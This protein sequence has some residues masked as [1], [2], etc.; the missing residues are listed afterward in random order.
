MTL[1][2]GGSGQLG[3]ALRILLP[4]CD[5]P[6]RSEL[7]L[8]DPDLV[9]KVIA[10]NPDCIINCAAY[11]D[12]DRAEN[13][14]DLATSVNATA[15]GDLASA[16]SELDVPFVTI[17]TDYVFDGRATEPYMESSRPN[18]INAYG[19]SKL[20]GERIALG[21]DGTLVVR[22]SWLI[23]RTHD[24][25]VSTVVAAARS[26]SVGVVEGQQGTPTAVDDLAQA[27]VDAVEHRVTGLLHLAAPP[28][29]S[30]LGLAQ[31]AL[32][33][34]GIDPARAVG[35]PTTTLPGAAARPGFSALASE[36]AEAADIA[37]LASW[38]DRLV[39][40]VAAFG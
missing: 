30:R 27:M 25:F 19:R 39:A 8:L 13:E 18:P 20:D 26:G 10:R 17:S 32:E 14:V 21:Y 24:N 22:T 37:A 3:S 1:L 12:V 29:V 9:A 2:L 6:P 40:I 16:A 34:A 11:T 35:V 15:V 23:S 31:A 4:G 33:A 7:N 36:R 38:R 5:A 28:V